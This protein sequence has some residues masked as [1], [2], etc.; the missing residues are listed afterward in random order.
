MGTRYAPRKSASRG[1]SMRDYWERVRWVDKTFATGIPLAR[2]V[3]W[4]CGWTI[5]KDLSDERMEEYRK[6]I[7]HVAEVMG[8]PYAD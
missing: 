2:D 5:A 8:K 4:M 1:A 6:D 3:I 7:Q